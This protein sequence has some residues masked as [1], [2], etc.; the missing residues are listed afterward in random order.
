MAK[1]E[2]SQCKFKGIAAGLAVLFVLAA[3][4][5]VGQ[6][7]ESNQLEADVN[8]LEGDLGELN[9]NIVTLDKR[10]NYLEEANTDLVSERVSLQE[11]VSKLTELLNTAA[12][13]VEDKKAE[14]E[15]LESKVPIVQVPLPGYEIDKLSLGDNVNI[16]LDDNEVE[17]LADEELELDGNDYDYH[18][19]I[20]L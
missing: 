18:E 10:T 5:G 14:I 9:A 1:K 7:N 6:Y 3:L 19:E 17:S 16:V 4:F 8:S 2:D 20:V 13:E 11:E 12:K 15:D